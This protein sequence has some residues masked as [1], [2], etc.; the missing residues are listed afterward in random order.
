MTN[1]RPY[2]K[3]SAKDLIELVELRSATLSTK[4][5]EKLIK[6]IELRKKVKKKLKPY[7]ALA[8]RN[9]KNL[10]NSNDTDHEDRRHLETEKQFYSNIMDKCRANAINHGDTDVSREFLRFQL[11]SISQTNEDL[12]FRFI[13]HKGYYPKITMDAFGYDIA[14]REAYF[15]FQSFDDKTFD[16]LSNVTVKELN[17]INKGAD[18]FI[19]ICSHKYPSEIANIN[20][21]LFKV[22]G[23]VK[24]NWNNYKTIT[25]I[26]ITNR[27]IKDNTSVLQTKKNMGKRFV[28]KT[29][30]LR[31]FY[32]N[33]IENPED[34]LPKQKQ[35]NTEDIPPPAIVSTNTK[36]NLAW[37]RKEIIIALDFYFNEY[38]NLPDKKSSKVKEVSDILRKLK[39][40]EIDKINSKYRNISGVYMKLMNF[41]NLNPKHLAKGL[42]S[43]S[44]LDRKIYNE[45]KDNQEELSRLAQKYKSELKTESPKPKTKKLKIP[46]K[47]KRVNQRPSLIDRFFD[48]LID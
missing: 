13:D 26:I 40:K 47:E 45:F 37:T 14:S 15:I 23:E 25:T 36:R 6:E 10:S 42:S 8:K 27:Y 30:D 5:L 12:N 9:L 48:W 34:T 44:K 7:L 38:P 22:A 46:S 43:G 19:D 3:K 16:Q 20:T 2:I 1:Q 18:K 32:F 29:F 41:N 17:K 31:N 39:L 11:Q 21:D 35:E 28:T 24:D 4:Q 33:N